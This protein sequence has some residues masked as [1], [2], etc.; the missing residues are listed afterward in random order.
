MMRTMRYLWL[1]H[2]NNDGK[3]QKI[4]TRISL[5]GSL[6]A[7]MMLHPTCEYSMNAE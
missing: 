5:A 2:N 4:E 7:R 6:E 3:V 1:M